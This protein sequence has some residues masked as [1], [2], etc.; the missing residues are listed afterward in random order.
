[1]RLLVIDTALGLCS[2]ALTED[3]RVLAA[4]SEPMVRGHQERLAGLVDELMRGAGADF[5]SLD[6]I[7]VTVGPGSFTG[8]RVG[9]AFA[10]GLGAAVGIPVAGVGTL[11]ALAG[12]AESSRLTAAVIDAR[13]GQVYVQY[14]K[15][16]IPINPADAVTVDEA[17]SQLINIESSGP[18]RLV[19]P[20][21][22]LLAER[23]PQAAVDD[24]A[25]PDPAAIARMATAQPITSPEPLYLRAADAK[26]PA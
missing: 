7:G 15:G 5:A 23:F 13:R 12:S 19:G 11:S 10:K 24:R 6:R 20:G 18:T 2:A 25:G 1:M 26:L 14:F 4:R 9:L 22:G 21:A 16:M 17:A 3:G 8:L